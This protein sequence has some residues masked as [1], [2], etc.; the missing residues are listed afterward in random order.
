MVVYG[1]FQASEVDAI[2]AATA[3]TVAQLATQHQ[4]SVLSPWQVRLHTPWT[5]EHPLATCPIRFTEKERVAKKAKQVA[6]DSVGH[7]TV[8]QVCRAAVATMS[9]K[10]LN[11]MRVIARDG[12]VITISYRRRDGEIIEEDCL[13]EKEEIRWRNRAYNTRKWEWNS[14]NVHLPYSLADGGQRMQ[15]CMISMGDEVTC[16][17]F[18]TADFQ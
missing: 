7:F 8:E 1:R 10:S 6:T 14:K 4:A 9:F 11:A 13:V 2:C 3:E 15:I 16:Q 5:G 17:D 12:K 18:T